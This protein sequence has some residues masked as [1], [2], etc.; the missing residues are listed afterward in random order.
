MRYQAIYEKFNA[1]YSGSE[2][3]IIYSSGTTGKSKGVI[4]SHFAIN[5]NADAIIE[6]MN[7]SISDCIYTIR[8]LSHSSTLTGELLVALKTHTKLLATSSAV[9]PRYIF[10]TITRNN[11]TILCL[12]PTLLS[13][14]CDELSKKAYCIS[15]LRAIYC[16]G[17]IMNGHIYNKAK[18][19][20]NTLVVYF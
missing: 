4:L 19:R 1:N 2:A 5:T 8:S 11:V 18:A 9:P 16:S 20:L 12:N 17:A 3:V 13:F 15:S 14:L 7:L 6:Y 10:D